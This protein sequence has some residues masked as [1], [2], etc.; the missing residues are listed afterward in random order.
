V[1]AANAVNLA[2]IRDC[3]ADFAA[4]DLLLVVEIL[5]YQLEGESDEAYRAGSPT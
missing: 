1:P 5:T 4:E 2:T 3:I